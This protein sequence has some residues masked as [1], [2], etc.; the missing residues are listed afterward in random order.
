MKG[1][2]HHKDCFMMQ[3]EKGQS[4]IYL[5]EHLLSRFD[6]P[7]PIEAK[8][9]VIDWK[10]QSAQ[11][12]P[13]FKKNRIKIP[14][15][16]FLPKSK[17]NLWLRP[18]PGFGDLSHP[19]TQLM[20]Q[21]MPQNVI[22]KKIL[23]IGCGNGILSLASI[24][25]GAIKATGIDIDEKALYQAKSNARLNTLETQTCFS[26]PKLLCIQSI[27]VFLMNMIRSEQEKAWEA[28]PLK[29]QKG[30]IGIV[31]GIL[32][33]EHDLF[34]RQTEKLGW[35]AKKTQQLEEWLAYIFET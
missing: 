7:S 22:R 32:E 18:G 35:K 31:S 34:L 24:L 27:D 14:L 8:E 3:D 26:L 23:D 4:W 30:S 20:L 17:K 10:A 29:L 21:L 11:Y 12:S 9:A 6:I 33:K 16:D 13:Y 19:T 15:K 5:P 1:L 25:F 28:L 2:S